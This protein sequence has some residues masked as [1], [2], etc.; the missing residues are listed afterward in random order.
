MYMCVSGSEELE[1]KRVV[2]QKMDEPHGRFYNIHYTSPMREKDSCW[3]SKFLFF[4]CCTL[5]LFFN[6]IVFI[7][8]SRILSFWQWKKFSTKKHLIFSSLNWLELSCSKRDVHI[9]HL[10]VNPRP[11]YTSVVY[12]CIRNWPGIKK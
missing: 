5:F 4:A 12:L 6:R 1:V 11:F 10:P 9:E 8:S 7:D 3:L 2:R